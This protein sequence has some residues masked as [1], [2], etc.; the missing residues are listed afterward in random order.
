MKENIM[1]FLDGIYSGGSEI[2]LKS[3]IKEL[4]KS[5]EIYITYQDKKKSNKVVVN[6]ILEY[7]KIYDINQEI[8][9]KALVYTTKEPEDSEALNKMQNNIKTDKKIFW[10]HCFTKGQIDFMNKLIKQKQIDSIVT[11]SKEAKKKLEN[12][13]NISKN[14]IPVDMIYNV[15][16]SKEIILKA[17]D[18][19][20]E[21][22][23]LAQSLNII[24]I[25]RIQRS[26]GYDRVYE[27]VK[28]LDKK[29]IDFKWFIIGQ[30]TG[31]EDE[32]T[33]EI[34]TKLG[35][36]SQVHVLGYK[37]NPYKYIKKCDYL[38]I[39]SDDE[40]WSLVITEAKILHIPC[41]ATDFDCV[42]EQ[43]ED[44][45]NSLILSLEKPNYEEII[46][47]MIPEKI[48]LQENLKE[49]Q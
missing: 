44:G 26:K 6:Q 9:V 43:L 36:Y 30:N 24:T 47:R 4:S 35:K 7:S 14:K 16:D 19:I 32:Y 28:M 33:K 20:E 39:L 17:Q 29:D 1:F 42:F 18:S 8:K 15:I 21:E 31:F 25:A 2:A 45:I 37:E 12:M 38:A 23:K 3:L 40:T 49:F 11:V 22:I 13:E 46:N 34:M 41:I 10:F 5:Y 48:K 27:L